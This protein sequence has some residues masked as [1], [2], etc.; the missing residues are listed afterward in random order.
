MKKT[1]K[2]GLLANFDKKL[3]KACEDLNLIDPI[4]LLVGL[5]NGQDLTNE[6]TIAT[7]LKEHEEGNGDNPPGEL[8]W[9]ELVD[10]IKYYYTAMP[11][12]EKTKLVAQKTLAEY[13]HSKK[14]SIE[15]TDKS[16]IEP[17][18]DLKTSEIKRF[19]RVFNRAY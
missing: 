11:I 2:I 17:V 6:S 16:T 1:E 10:M 13:Q 12:D 19:K 14:K 7:W 5:A 9:L 15:I 8:E 3:Q 4:V 18:G